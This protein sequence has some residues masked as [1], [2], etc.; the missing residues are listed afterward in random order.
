MASPLFQRAEAQLRQKGDERNTLYAHIGVLRLTSSA[1]INERSDEIAQLLSTNTLIA[2]DKQLRLFALTV[3]GDLD[4]ELDQ[5]AARQ[6]WTE[7]SRLATEMG[8][9]KWVYRAEGQLGFA[10]YYDGDL[11]SCQRRVAAALI[12]A[13]KAQDVGAQIFFLSTIAHGYQMQRLLL[14]VAIDYANKAIALASA[15]PDA[16]SP[17]IAQACLIRALAESGR[18]AEAKQLVRSLLA[19][20]NL[21]Y[22]ERV[23]YL[24]AA[25]DVAIAQHEYTGGIADLQQA[26]RIAL[27]RGAD[28]EAADLQSELSDLYLKTGNLVEA[29]QCARS[30]VNTLGHAG[31]V[32][33]L[34]AKLDALAQVLIARKL[35]SAASS[36]YNRAEA[37][38]DTLLGRADSVIVKTALITGADQLYAHHFALIAEHFHDAEAAYNVVEQARGRAVADLLLSKAAVSPQAV[39]TERR[40]SELRLRMASA[41]SPADIAKL[42]NAIFLDEQ[43][44]AVSPDLTILR[45][46]RFRAVPLQ[47]LQAVLNP[48]EVVLEYVVAEPNSYVLVVTR[49]AR[50][51]VKLTGR[52]NIDKLVGAYTG[53]VKQSVSARQEAR[54]L[55]EALL[56]PISEIQSNSHYLVVPDGSLNLVP[57]DALIDEHDQFVL[58]G[59]V[60]AYEP[61]CTTLYLLRTTHLTGKPSSGL[62]SVGGVPYE[63]AANSGETS[64]QPYSSDQKFEDLPNS[65]AEADIA[66][67][68][69]KISH[70]RQLEGAAATES[71]LKS[72]LAGGYE[73]VHLAVHAITSDD[74]DRA[75]LIVLS[76]PSRGED[77]F[78]EASEIVQMRLRAKLVVLSACDTNVGPIQGE[79]GISALSTAFLLA[80]AKTVV[81][82]LW[83]IEDKSSLILMK[84]FYQHLGAGQSVADAMSSAKRDVLTK[85]G[86]NS[87]PIHWAAY[88]VQG[89]EPKESASGAGTLTAAS[90]PTR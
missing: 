21:D 15:H 79:E 4:G 70:S 77:G 32:M 72:A 56:E 12:A 67:T 9:T 24:T 73:Y 16:G 39:A 34:P 64:A 68:E 74:P 5:A 58:E 33:L 20:P 55:Y 7:V 29:E 13:M 52:K 28:R 62:L 19:N 59:H 63:L 43:A 89:A 1:T 87:S 8:E 82:T 23:N 66:A 26:I 45:T 78:V 14:P 38:Q 48:S 51:I 44:R 65:A 27:G 84:Q 60:T 30:A 76:D 17:M 86:A 75:S 85:F 35:Y 61:S 40:I 2:H 69:L 71:N 90:L 53:A 50:R 57:L 81:S 37:L 83:P 46:R 88:V 31:A 49:G 80:G 36:A 41:K 3:K 10:D 11:E 22:A 47:N 42:R 18:V 54:Q 6:D 25:A